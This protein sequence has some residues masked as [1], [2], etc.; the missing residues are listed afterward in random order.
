MK[1]VQNIK[2][3]TK[4]KVDPGAM[5]I[6]AL[7][8]LWAVIIIYPFYN[9]VLV[10]IVPLRIYVKN[11]FLLYPPAVDWSSYE[12]ILSWGPM[13]TGLRTTLLLVLAGVPYSLFLTVT[14]SYVL[15]KPI[16]GQK[17]VNLYVVFTMFFSGGL[18]ANFLLV[19]NLGLMDNYMSMILP[20][21][22]GVMNMMI[23]RSYFRTI[24]LEL[25][26]AARI[27]GAGEYTILVRIYLP[28]A[29]PMLATITLFDVVGRWNEWYSGMLYMRTMSKWPLQ[30]II[31]NT[32]AS[33]SAVTAGVP[34]SVK[35]LVFAESLQMAAVIVTIIPIAVV[36]PFLQKYFVKG[37]TLGGV[38]G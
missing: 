31:R 5:L 33:T 30:L 11:P 37:L 7:L 10:S 16:P 25:E 28:L 29:K 9:S 35:P 26:E 24:P 8:I 2:P 14:M 3:R 22:M 1:V 23:M 12:T 36:Y 13:L 32:L 18:I 19:K 38:K 15:S 17:L 20:V 21:G 4:R 27:D 34:D 6:I